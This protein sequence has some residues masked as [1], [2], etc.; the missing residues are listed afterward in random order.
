MLARHEDRLHL[1][2]LPEFPRSLREVLLLRRLFGSE[3]EALKV[4]LLLERVL[5]RMVELERRSWLP[6]ST[7]FVIVPFCFNVCQNHQSV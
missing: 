7:R 3:L 5:T 6:P 2:A 1:L 4:L